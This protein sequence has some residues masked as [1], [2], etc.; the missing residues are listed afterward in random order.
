MKRRR[1][2]T[3]IVTAPIVLIVCPAIFGF[4]RILA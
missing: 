1:A 2:V 3:I 4:D